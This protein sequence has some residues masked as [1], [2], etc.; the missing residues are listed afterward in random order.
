MFIFCANKYY[1]WYTVTSTATYFTYLMYFV[2]AGEL[3]GL[4][5]TKEW[6]KSSLSLLHREQTIREVKGHPERQEEMQ[7]FYYWERHTFLRL[8]RKYLYSILICS[9]SFNGLE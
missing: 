7:Q 1:M 2:W 6:V 8:T 9:F 5:E 4:H 3:L